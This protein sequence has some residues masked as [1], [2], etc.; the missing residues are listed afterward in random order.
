VSNQPKIVVAPRLGEVVE[1]AAAHIRAAAAAAIAARGRFRMALAGGST[2]R[3]LYPE[4]VTSVDWTRA[5]LFFGDERAV[6][7]DAPQSNF[8]MV[9][10][11]LLDPA[12]VPPGNVVRWRSE[13]PD[14]DAAARDYE[15]ALTAD[16]VAPWLDLALLGLGPDGHTASLF[17]GTSALAEESRLAVAVDVA[18]MGTRR[19]TLTYPALCG[20]REVC[21]LVVGREKAAALAAVV[22]AGHLPAARIARRDGPVTIFCDESAASALKSNRQDPG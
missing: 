21:F 11:T 5:K 3:A 13:D 18:E 10:E 7:P 17:P 4:L 6:P 9:R 1:A 15:E 14:L 19:L 12:H 22:E 20:A 8:R 16:A 2:P